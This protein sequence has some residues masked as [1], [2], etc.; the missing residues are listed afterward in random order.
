MKRRITSRYIL[1]IISFAFFASCDSSEGEDP[2]DQQLARLQS[3]WNVSS[4]V[5][6]GVTITGFENFTLTIGTFTYTSTNGLDVWPDSGTWEFQG[7]SVSSVIRD[8]GVVMTWE[9]ASDNELLISFNFVD[10]NGRHSGI[11][12]SYQFSLNK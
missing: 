1:L 7:Q 9:L 12:G 8:D 11:G 2:Q 6:D 10:P 4:V 5:L 3:T